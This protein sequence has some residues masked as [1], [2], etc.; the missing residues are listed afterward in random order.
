MSTFKFRIPVQ[1][2]EHVPKRE[3]NRFDAWK[4]EYLHFTVEA[5]YEEE[6]LVLFVSSLRKAV[7][8]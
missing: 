6:A 3:R 5:E 1:I 2:R 7:R 4:D 8:S